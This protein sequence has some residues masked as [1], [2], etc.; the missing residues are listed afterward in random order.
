MLTGDLDDLRV[1]WAAAVGRLGESVTAERMDGP[2][3][4]GRL[5]G[6]DVRR[7]VVGKTRLVPEEVRH[8]W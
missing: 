5:D 2:T 7:V 8:V 6:V 1:G 3:V 4:H